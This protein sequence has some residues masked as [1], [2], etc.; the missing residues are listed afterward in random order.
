M[1]LKCSASGGISHQVSGNVFVAHTVVNGK[2]NCDT[3]SRLAP[4]TPAT[5][6]S[7]VNQ[8]ITTAVITA[9]D[10]K[11]IPVELSPTQKS[12]TIFT[13]TDAVT[14]MPNAVAELSATAPA[15]KVTTNISSKSDNTLWLQVGAFNKKSNANHLAEKL[16]AKK[17]DVSITKNKN[18]FV[19]RIEQLLD[20][21][22]QQRAQ[23]IAYSI[24]KKITADE[25]PSFALQLGAFVDESRAKKQVAQLQKDNI[26]ASIQ[27]IERGGKPL[28]R[29]IVADYSTKNAAKQA[30]KTVLT[31]TGIIG[32][33]IKIR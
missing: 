31:K 8:Q 29:V 16:R 20:K 19:V 23:R 10:T 33:V 13:T 17:L 14:L 30:Q 1:F 2:S 4:T 22:A 11:L 18:L 25:T 5:I 3:L 6:D 7:P 32:H 26:N 12:I 27:N 21:A 9:Q 28:F 15:I 24:T